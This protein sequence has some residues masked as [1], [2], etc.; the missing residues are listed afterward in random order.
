MTDGIWVTGLEVPVY[1]KRKKQVRSSNLP[2]LKEFSMF[3]CF[4][5]FALSSLKSPKEDAIHALCF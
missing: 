4:V 1:A 3:I 5:L 2:V